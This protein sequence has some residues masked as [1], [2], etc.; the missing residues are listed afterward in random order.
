MI[1]LKKYI[2]PILTVFLVCLIFFGYYLNKK[3]SA[4]KKNEISNLALEL[5]I[6]NDQLAKIQKNLLK[7]GYNI[8]NIINQNKI[9][10]KKIT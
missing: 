10:F 9:S 8:N 6:R 7:N 4:S 1:F 5:K 3:S 2:Y